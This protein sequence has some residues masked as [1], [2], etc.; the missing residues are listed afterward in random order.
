[1][2]NGKPLIEYEYSDTILLR[3]MAWRIPGFKEGAAV[4][5]EITPK[6]YIN[7]PEDGIDP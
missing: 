2:I 3:L 6:Q 4:T 5:I 1:M 7:I